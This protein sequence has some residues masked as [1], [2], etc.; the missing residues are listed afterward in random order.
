[1]PIYLP[2]TLEEIAI[3]WP[4]FR[5]NMLSLMLAKRLSLYRLAAIVSVE[6]SAV[7][8]W[9]RKRCLPYPVTRRR[10][11][12]V[13]KVT[14][15]ILF[16]PVSRQLRKQISKV[17]RSRLLLMVRYHA[18]RE[19]GARDLSSFFARIPETEELHARS[20]EQYKKRLANQASGIIP[21]RGR[22]PLHRRQSHKR[23]PRLAGKKVSE[24]AKGRLLLIYKRHEYL[25]K[26]ESWRERYSEHYQAMK[27]K[28][29]FINPK[30]RKR[31]LVDMM[32]QEIYAQ[33]RAS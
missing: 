7:A 14:E 22:P 15:D 5:A 9:F 12:K 25:K 30:Y 26:G 24:R 28:R 31:R 29:A 2:S 4:R 1:M 23:K 20:K 10:L 19:D 8:L 21:R 13:F 18:D 32:P 16:A 3:K 11:C 33:G 6:K 27:A 17:P